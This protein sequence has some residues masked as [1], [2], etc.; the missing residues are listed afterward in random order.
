MTPGGGEGAGVARQ[1]QDCRDL[2][3]RGHLTVSKVYSDNDISAYNG[4]VR[5]GFEAMLDAIK[6]GQHDVLLCWHT[7]RLYRS[8][9]DMERVI[10]VCEAAGVPVR[11]VNG[12]DLDLGHATGKAVARILGSVSRMESEHKAERQRRANLQRA[13]AGAWWSSHRCFGYTEAG[14]VCQ[15]EASMIQQAA[16]EVLAGASLR[17]IARQWNASGV[18]S[19]RGAAWNASRVKRM[20]INPRYA[21]LRT[22]HGKVT[23]AGVWQ[24]ILD[25]DTHAGL[26]A[27]LRNPS[28]GAAVSYERKYIGSHRYLC[29]IC[30][31]P[32]QHTQSMHSDGRTYH[33]YKCSA[34]AHLSRSQ[35][36]LDAYV[37]SVVLAYLSDDAKLRKILARNKSAVDVNELRT[38]RAALAAKKDGLAT[39]FADDV[40]D[41]AGVRRESAKLSAKIAGIDS[42]LAEQALRNPVDELLKDGVDMLETRWAALSPDMKGK[43][44]D[45]V[46]TVVVNPSP[47]GRYFK[48][49]CIDFVQKGGAAL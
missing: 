41:G 15:P 39:L 11:T 19:T 42:A 16:A 43:V 13:Q 9:K 40:L 35:P 48:P 28:R 49:E 32:L 5:P 34:S 45:K 1:E 29:G 47:K 20:L 25:A 46:C 12:G 27:V 18:T 44:I 30:K 3:K 31:A 6:R 38:R 24:A 4:V 2:A 8:I 17:A 37:E 23:G 22:Y 14:E 36:E 21:G 10:E 33:R 26:V 7:D